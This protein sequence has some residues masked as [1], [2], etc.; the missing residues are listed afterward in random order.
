MSRTKT[1]LVALAIAVSGAV[2]LA[3]AGESAAEE[4]PAGS[5]HPAADS[6]YGYDGSRPLRSISP[7]TVLKVRPTTLHQAGL[8]TVV[9]G[10]QLLYRTTGERGEATTTVATVFR[11]RVEVFSKPRLVSVQ[12]AYDA[13]DAKCDPSYMLAGGPP[14]GGTTYNVPSQAEITA[15]LTFLAQGYTVVVSDYEGPE[16]QWFAGRTSGRGVLDGI[17]AAIRHDPDLT[18]SSPA[19]MIGYSGGGIAT[20]WASQYAAAYAPE[21]NIVGAAAGGF[22][23]SIQNMFGYIDGSPLWAGVM[24][25]ILQGVARAYDVSLDPWLSDHGKQVMQTVSTQCIAEFQSQNTGVRLEELF[26]PAY[27]DPFTVPAIARLARNQLM[28]RDGTPDHPV[29]YRV[30]NMDGTGDTIIVAADMRRLAD[31]YCRRGVE[32]D[33]RELAGMEHLTAAV[34]FYAEAEL[35]VGRRLA[36]EP[37]TGAC[38]GIDP[39]PIPTTPTALP[40]LP[41]TDRSTE[42]TAPAAGVLPPG[43]RRAR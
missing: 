29:F 33:Y 14:L 43:S 1:W 22:V 20:Q 38:T 15:V 36:G 31:E 5:T 23:P 37:T 26:Q 42:G 8:P 21:L 41:V 40:R 2:P 39:G 6:F 28:G 27:A 19:A 13:L 11:P 12:F 25:P 35:W 30:G 24:A 17:R 4:P 18:G 34:T 3:S 32:V 7:G 10:E 16:L 9:Q